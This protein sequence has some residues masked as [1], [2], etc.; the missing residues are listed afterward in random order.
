MKGNSKYSWEV[1]RNPEAPEAR[2]NQSGGRKGNVSIGAT[3]R[4]VMEK[5]RSV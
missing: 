1:I 4:G 5:G 3:A 2:E